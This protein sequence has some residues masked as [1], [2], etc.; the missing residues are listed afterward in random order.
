[1]CVEMARAKGWGYRCKTCD[2]DMCQDCFIK[3]GKS[4]GEGRLRGDKGVKHEKEVTPGMYLKQAMRLVAPHY[5]LVA[6]AFVCLFATAASQLFLP[7]FQGEILDVVIHANASGH[8]AMYIKVKPSF[9][10][11]FCLLLY[12]RSLSVLYC[13][14]CGCGRVRR[15][16]RTV[17]QRPWSPP[18]LRS[19]HQAIPQRA[20]PG[21][22]CLHASVSLFTHLVVLFFRRCGLLRRDHHRAAD[23]P[24]E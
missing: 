14:E 9:Q 5:L 19:S 13:F 17:L 10:L 18:Q 1:M 20:Q 15:G 24:A 11:L 7:N 2:F 23:V 16:S 21:F 22:A 12:F 8:F 4:S 3:K 6:V